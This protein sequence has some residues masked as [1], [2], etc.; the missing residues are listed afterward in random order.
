MLLVAAAAA[1]TFP[2]LPG[3]YSPALRKRPCLMP[4]EA[5]TLASRGLDRVWAS[6]SSEQVFTLS[7]DFCSCSTALVLRATPFIQAG[8]GATLR[9][10][11]LIPRP[12]ILKP[13][14][15]NKPRCP[16]NP[17]PK[18]LS[19]WAWIVCQ[20]TQTLNREPWT[21]SLSPRHSVRQA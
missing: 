11:T 19:A 12:E 4:G 3:S 10:R 6:G 8:L 14:F 7:K 21:L 5:S 16:L 9:W 17:K 18:S 2:E 1:F 15:C 13:F 20:Q